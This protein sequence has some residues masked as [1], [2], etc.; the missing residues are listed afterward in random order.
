M[1][2]PNTVANLSQSHQQSLESSSAGCRSDSTQG[3]KERKRPERQTAA[4]ILKILFREKDGLL[5]FVIAQDVGMLSWS[6]KT[7][8]PRREG[9]APKRLKSLRT[10]RDSPIVMW[11]PYRHLPLSTGSHRSATNID[12]GSIAVPCD[13]T[14]ANFTSH[15]LSIH[16]H[17]L[18]QFQKAMA[19][20]GTH[21]TSHQTRDMTVPSCFLNES[22]H[23][24]GDG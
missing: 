10:V 17:P 15:Q 4:F 1:H 3:K 14:S 23:C 22:E 19:V 13:D 2:S 24:M 16:F 9:Q 21:V 18:H 12:S 6:E 5:P 7:T 8:L 20:W 11:S